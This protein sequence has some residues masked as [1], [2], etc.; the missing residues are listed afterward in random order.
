MA[1]S[2]LGGGQSKQLTITAPFGFDSSP[3]SH[4]VYAMV[5][6]VKQI[7]ELLETNNIASSAVGSEDTESMVFLPLITLHP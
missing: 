5:D 3:D 2:S 1:V 6:S 7:D 4:M